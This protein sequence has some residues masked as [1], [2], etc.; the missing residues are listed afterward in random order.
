MVRR[1]SNCVLLCLHAGQICQLCSFDELCYKKDQENCKWIVNGSLHTLCKWLDY[2][3]LNCC[4]ANEACNLH[5]GEETDSALDASSSQRSNE[6]LWV[7]DTSKCHTSK[8]CSSHFVSLCLSLVILHPGAHNAL[9]QALELLTKRRAKKNTW[10]APN[11]RLFAV[12][13]IMEILRASR[14]CG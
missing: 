13:K 8:W 4:L 7:S 5:G 2:V 11:Q 9:V 1:Y 14:D 6:F 10:P 12:T 3:R